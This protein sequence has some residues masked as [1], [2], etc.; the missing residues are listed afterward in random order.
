[1]ERKDLLAANVKIFKVQGQALDKY[2]KKT[3]KGGLIEFT[4]IKPDFIPS[5]GNMKFTTCVVEFCIYR[6]PSRE[7]SS[8]LLQSNLISIQ[9]W[10]NR[11]YEVYYAILVSFVYNKN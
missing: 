11:K 9:I 4:T 3:V 5:F 7:A 8:S 6:R 1:M 2:A 10:K